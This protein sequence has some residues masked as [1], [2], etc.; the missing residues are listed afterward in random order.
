M[1]AIY[2][3]DNTIW[4]F[5]RTQIRPDWEWQIPI[6][7]PDELWDA[8]DNNQVDES[9]AVIV[10]SPQFYRDAMSVG[11]ADMLESF[12]NLVFT[13]SQSALVM[14]INFW[15]DLQQQIDQNILA[16]AGQQGNDQ[17]VLGKYWWINPQSPLPDVDS[18]IKEYVNSTYSDP[19]TVK[20][21]ADAEGLTVMGDGQNGGGMISNAVNAIN[22][23]FNGADDDPYGE[24]QFT[25]NYGKKG[26]IITVTSSK[27][28]A[29]KTTVS[30]GAAEWISLSSVMAARNHIIPK[31][32]KVCVVD[33]DVHDSQIGSVIGKWQ[34]T[35]LEVALNGVSEATLEHTI[36]HDSRSQCDFLLSPKL[37]KAADTIPA[38][39]FQEIIKTLQ[40][41]YDIIV[42][43]TSV[44]YTSE[45]LGQ[46]IYPM[47]DRILFVTTLDRR[48]VTGLRKWILFAGSPEDKGGAGV[49]LAKVSVVINR[50]QKNVKMTK[51]E[52]EDSVRN[53]TQKA[54]EGLDM[55][56]PVEDQHTPRLIGAIPDI[57][58][59]MLM[60][61][62]NEQKF[63]MS[64][65]IPP[66]EQ[67]ISEFCR[68]IVPSSFR[69]KLPRLINP[70]PKH[71]VTR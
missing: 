24:P 18:A 25:N 52:I 32:L 43:D 4:E 64:L 22:D 23:R 57:P 10:V 2:V 26:Q 60:R 27:G 16:Y 61:C 21:I 20:I 28:G 38:P 19:E 17:G 41:M 29:G 56:I 62:C 40:Y 58:N 48:S 14:I 51:R 67:S 55:T 37:P 36:I 7:N 53:A 6:H 9:T 15:P 69:D 33:L 50:G 49:D 31:P 54:Y 70:G 46:F 68:R 30:L 39:K 34:P 42:L 63:W 45:L 44:E 47:S 1:K 35:I 71:A 66:F 8:I 11:D 5:M 13:A 59:G 3:G 12:Q 65:K